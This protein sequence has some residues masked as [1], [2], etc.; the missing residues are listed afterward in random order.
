VPPIQAAIET[1]V[2]AAEAV[3]AVTLDAVEPEARVLGDVVGRG[4]WK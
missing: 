3:E 4:A 1:R 2:E